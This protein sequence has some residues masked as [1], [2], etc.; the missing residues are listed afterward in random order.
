MIQT[1]K[2]GKPCVCPMK[3]PCSHSSRFCICTLR[4]AAPQEMPMAQDLLMRHL[5]GPKLPYLYYHDWWGSPI[6]HQ[7]TFNSTILPCHFLSHASYIQTLLNAD[8][9]G[10]RLSNLQCSASTIYNTNQTRCT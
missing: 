7:D 8:F 9:P 5:R 3:Q 6:S 2:E 4:C 1:P 10:V